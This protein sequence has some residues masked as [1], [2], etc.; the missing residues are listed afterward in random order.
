MDG[1]E[2]YGGFTKQK[3]EDTYYFEPTLEFKFS[4]KN[5]K[6]AFKADIN[7]SF[8]LIRNN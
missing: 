1:I 6:S 7:E 8:E 4:L 3:S 2:I 5:K